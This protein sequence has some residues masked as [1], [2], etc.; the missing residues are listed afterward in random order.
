MDP[1]R[2]PLQVPV[3]LTE[4]SPE[5]KVLEFTRRPVARDFKGMPGELAQDDN[6]MLLSRL[7]NTEFAVIEKLDGHDYM[8]ACGVLQA[9]LGHGPGIGV[10]P[11][12]N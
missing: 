10:R 11:S 12:G 5:V 4:T 1:F 2:L 8:Q 9:F 3:R 7:T 6:M